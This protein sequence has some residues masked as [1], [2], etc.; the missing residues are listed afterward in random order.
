M[1]LI[2]EKHIKIPWHNST[3]KRYE[4]LGYVFTNY[5]ELFDV[6]I[7][8]IPPSSEV[9]ITAICDSC[10]VEKQMSLH[11][12]N[13]ITKKQ[14]KVYICRNCFMNSKIIKYEE[15]L[16]D[17]NC[18]GYILLTTKYKYVTTI[19]LYICLKHGEQ[20]MRAANFH[21]GKRCRYCCFEAAHDRHAFTPDEVYN[22]ISDLGGKLLNKEDYINQDEKNLRIVCPRCHENILLTSL[23]HFQQ[24]GGQSCKE[25]YKKESV[26]ERRIRQWLENHEFEFVQEKW[27]DDCR[28]IN[29]LPFDFY[30]QDL[31]TI[32]EFDGKQHFEE[33]HFFSHL[34]NFN[35]SVTAYTQ[36]HDKIKNDYCKKNNI[37]LIRIPY[38]RTNNI[39]KI[40][41]EK[42]IA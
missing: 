42:L 4:K 29:P 26:G 6:K 13:S 24:H 25:C 22:K 5:T 15:I 18:D 34:N 38:T 8:D 17:A 7:D 30:L 1:C 23:K 36:H 19:I 20:K 12:Y 10:G 11:A 9:T 31:N 27:F 37:N 21:N 32:I 16:N 35:N 3:R 28:D 2:K 14:S 39:E 40:L 33:N 41:E